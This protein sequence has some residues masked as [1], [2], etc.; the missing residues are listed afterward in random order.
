VGGVGS[1][2]QA[3]AKIC[4]G[5]SAVQL[6]TAMVFQGLSVVRDIA[7]GLDG[8]LARDGFANVAEAVGTGRDDWLSD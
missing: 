6:Y 2:E 7:T 8:L 1:A 5:A 4:A 3:Y